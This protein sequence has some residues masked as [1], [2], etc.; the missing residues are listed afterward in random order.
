MHMD[1]SHSSHALL[2]LRSYIESMSKYF[3]VKAIILLRLQLANTQVLL[4]IHLSEIF[5]LTT[6]T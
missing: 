5:R 6:D 4:Q 1:R 2:R 3:N